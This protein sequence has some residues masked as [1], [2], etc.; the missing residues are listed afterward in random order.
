MATDVS[1]APPS[2]VPRS[3]RTTAGP[4]EVAERTARDVAYVL[5]GLPLTIASFV[6]MVVGLSV[7]V[8]LLVVWVGLPLLVGTLYAARGL[9]LVQRARLAIRR[10]V[11][12]PGQYR[13][14]QPERSV[15]GRLLDRLRDPQA[16][17]DV[18]HAIVAFPLAIA[19]WCVTLTWTAATG[20][21][22]TYWLWERWV[23]QSPENETLADILDIGLSDSLAYLLVGLVALAT[24]PWVARA[25][26]GAE[27]GLARILLANQQAA[28]LQER[29]DAS[30]RKRAAAASAEA[31]VRER[32]ERDLHDGPQQRLVRLGMDLAAAERRLA[33]DPEA[34][35]QLIAEARAHSQAALEEL[36][37]LSRGIAPPLLVDRGLRA[38]VEDLASRAAVPTEVEVTLDPDERLDSAVEQAAYFTI[39]E[40]LTN[41]AKH[42]R[43]TRAAVRVF[44]HPE[45]ATRLVVS[46]TDDGVGGAD[47]AKGHGLRGLHERLGALDA[48]L[49]V[50]S[51][52]GGPTVVRAEVPCG[53]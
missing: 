12:P 46:V 3:A 4:R 31:A 18:L 39:A 27:A 51:P 14:S 42:A 22:L 24:L 23:P 48:E 1:S 11:I 50:H 37:S 2:A 32:L 5:V 36:R 29:L 45:D 44:R 30:A 9:A 33:D 34:A 28:E 16:W 15:G 25:C 47:L 52:V 10:E 53:S 19:T 26:A 7:S 6:L 43:A 35:R 49:S 38:A 13:A 21:G 17:L 40:A 20:V 41:I 8:P